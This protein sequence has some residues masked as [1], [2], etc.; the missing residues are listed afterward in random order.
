MIFSV[1]RCVG[2]TFRTLATEKK[3]LRTTIVV[4]LRYGHNFWT[5]TVYN[6]VQH[7]SMCTPDTCMDMYV[8]RTL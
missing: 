2:V 7:A 4:G 8:H 5:P 3:N 1:V 6:C